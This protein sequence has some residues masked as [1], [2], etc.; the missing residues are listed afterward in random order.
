M[1]YATISPLPPVPQRNQSPEQ[2]TLNADAFLGAL[3]GFVTQLNAFAAALSTVAGGSAGQFLRKNTGA[4]YDASYQNLTSADVR[5]ALGFTPL[6]NTAASVSS[7]L[8]FTPANPGAPTNFTAGLQSG[9]A[10]VITAAGPQT[11]GGPLTTLNTLNINATAATAGYFNYAT[12][13][14]TDYAVGKPGVF[15][16]KSAGNSTTWNVGVYDPNGP[17]GVL[18]ILA[19]Q[20]V[21]PCQT[22]VTTTVGPQ[23]TISDGT[24]YGAIQFGTP[25]V[26]TAANHSHI[27]N[28]GDGTVNVFRGNFGAGTL[29]WQFD[30]ANNLLPGADAG[31]TFGSGSRRVGQITTSTNVIVTSDMREKTLAE[32][33]L[34]DNATG[35]LTDRGLAVAARQF[36]RPV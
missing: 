28:Q 31:P 21:H 2:F 35:L 20:V 23:L 18:N 9:G 29:M 14:P 11:I 12:I 7:A 6:A 8:G 34:I 27:V 16:A 3:P 25:G 33:G 5:T 13:A 24:N 26:G 19:G 22:F 4:D 36:H 15:I 1:A 30:A 32:C 10:N 17:A